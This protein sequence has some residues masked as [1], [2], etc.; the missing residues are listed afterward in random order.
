VPIPSFVKARAAQRIQI[1]AL[2]EL[3]ERAERRS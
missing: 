1:Q 2:R 3:R